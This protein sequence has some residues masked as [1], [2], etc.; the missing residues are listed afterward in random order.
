MD[1]KETVGSGIGF[2]GALQIAFIVLKLCDVIEWSWFWVLA[3]LWI[4]L[5]ALVILLIIV[6]IYAIASRND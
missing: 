3:P 6:A 1:S 4:N 5:A 2:S